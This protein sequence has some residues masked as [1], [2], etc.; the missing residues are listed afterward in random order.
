M[1]N[2]NYNH[3]R[4]ENDMKFNDTINQ[5][6]QLMKLNGKRCFMIDENGKRITSADNP[7][8]FKMKI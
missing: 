2:G 3:N 5:H 8:G 1:I 4:K 6:E 7:S